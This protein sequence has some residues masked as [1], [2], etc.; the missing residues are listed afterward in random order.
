MSIFRTDRRGLTWSEILVFVIFVAGIGGSIAFGL[1]VLK[2]QA[3]DSKRVT[4]L[5]EISKALEEYYD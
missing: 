1:D 4:E 5:K 2:K 3:A